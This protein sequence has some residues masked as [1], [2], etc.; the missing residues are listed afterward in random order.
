MHG[1]VFPDLHFPLK[2]RLILNL[3][4]VPKSPIHI[5]FQEEGNIRKTL[6]FPVNGSKKPII[7]AESI[8]GVLRSMA[9]KL[10]KSTLLKRDDIDELTKL[11]VQFHN[12]DIHMP[13]SN[14]EMEPVLKKLKPHLNDFEN[15]LI[16]NNIFP[17]SDLND[18]RLN[19]Q[20]P[21]FLL[22]FKCPICRLFGSQFFAGKMTFYDMIIEGDF[23][24]EQY[25]LSSIERN[26]KK[27][28][29]D[30]LF[31]VISIK[32]CEDLRIKLKVVIDNIV[33]E[34]VDSLLLKVLMQF[35]LK[36]GVQIGGLK[37]KGFGRVILLEDESYAVVL[38]FSNDSL[39]NIKKLLNYDSAQK[40]S[41]SD[42]I[43][44]LRGGQLE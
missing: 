15:F 9:S 5:G 14:E 25:T 27:V 16:N 43:F 4:F 21:E 13:S 39:L 38:E 10:A 35:I 31:T 28:A 23:E 29:E 19:A 8:K 26:R 42:L 37:S 36:F 12:K 17:E 32:P 40:K 11:A 18:W 7:P 1:M 30:H 3:V 22:S 33:H 41:I 24:L 20:L 6:L 2:N 44:Y 34:K